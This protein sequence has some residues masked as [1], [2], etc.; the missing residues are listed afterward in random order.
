ME[1]IRL[2]TL[3]PLNEKNDRSGSHIPF[4]SSYTSGVSPGLSSSYSNNLS[5]QVSIASPQVHPSKLL[6]IIDKNVTKL[7]PAVLIHENN[8]L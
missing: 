5:R 2:E 6:N 7:D 3:D 1:F 8:A 4:H